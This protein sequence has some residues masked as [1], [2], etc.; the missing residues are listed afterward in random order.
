MK[1][2][3]LI[4]HLKTY[5]PEQTITYA[6]WSIDDVSCALEQI[7]LDIDF[8]TEDEKNEV[9]DYVEDHEDAEY[10][11]S[12]INFTE[13]IKYLFKDKFPIEEVKEE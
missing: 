8:L 7:N 1:V 2:R 10:G 3:E 11:I 6:L 13:G 9:I 12:W 4:E 5:D